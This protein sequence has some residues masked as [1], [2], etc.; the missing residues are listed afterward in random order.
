MSQNSGVSYINPNGYAVNDIEDATPM[1]IGKVRAD[2]TWL[3]QRYNSTTGSMSYANLSNNPTVI[4]Y[5]SAWT[6][7]A[8]LVY[9]GYETLK[10]V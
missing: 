2:G 9:G 10:G 4:D 1:Y 6:A 5:G 3:L 8:S 7:R